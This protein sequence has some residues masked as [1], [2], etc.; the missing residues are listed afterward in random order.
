[1]K[2]TGVEWN[3]VTY[4]AYNKVKHHLMNMKETISSLPR[5]YMRVHG[6]VVIDGLLFVLLY[7][8][9]GLSKQHIVID[10]NAGNVVHRHRR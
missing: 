7:K 1:M 3:A 10:V 6:H 2:K 9:Y 4:G 8:L 5:R